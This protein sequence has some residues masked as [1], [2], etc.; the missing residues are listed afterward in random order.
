M[1]FRR[2]AA[3]ITMAGLLCSSFNVTATGIPVVDAVG[4]L[5]EMQHWLERVK[6]WTETATHYR[7]QLEAY[8]N[9]LATQTGLRDIVGLINQGKS[10][11]NDLANLQKQGITLNDL[12]VSGGAPSGALDRLYN[13]YKA[14]DV[15]DAQQAAAYLSVCKQETVNKAYAVEQTVE[16]QNSIN[17]TLDDISNLSDRIAN[18]KDSKE[19]M[20]LSNAMQV[21]TVRLNTLTTQWEMNMKAAEQ[22]DK[23]LAAKREK[24]HNQQQLEAPVMEF[25]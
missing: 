21:K 3:A 15:C 22:R 6:Q 7:S 16:V 17:D 4:N 10:L 19:S 8:K 13:K 14:F 25:N 2:L 20:D 18:S 24:A 9:Q 5:Q 23:L 11:K 12:L 1:K